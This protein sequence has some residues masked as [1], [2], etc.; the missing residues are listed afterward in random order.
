MPPLREEHVLHKTQWSLLPYPASI[1]PVPLL[2]NSHAFWLQQVQVG[3]IIQSVGR[4]P[5]ADLKSFRRAVELYVGGS[6]LLKIQRNRQ[7]MEVQLHGNGGASGSFL[8]SPPQ[9]ASP[10]AD[11]TS[12]QRSF[13]LPKNVGASYMGP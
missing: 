11:A 8:P 6:L 3:D 2:S 4:T 7:T 12:Y 5:I 1:M 9:K 10:R 13:G